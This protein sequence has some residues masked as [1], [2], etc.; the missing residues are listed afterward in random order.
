MDRERF[1][2]LARLLA[3]TGSRR[4]M[5]GALLGVSLF[6]RDPDV[7]AQHGNGKGKGKRNSD[8]GQ[9][10]Q[11]AGRPGAKHH[12]HHQH[13]HTQRQRRQQRDRQDR[14]G[15]QHPGPPVESRCGTKSC[16]PPEPGSDRTAC[17]FNGFTGQAFTG[18]DLHGAIFR[19]IDGRGTS[20]AG[21]D[22]RGAVFTAACLR[23]ASFR[24][25]QGA[26]ATWEGACLVDADFTG[27]DRG[28]DVAA[29]DGALLCR[30]IRPDGAVANRDCGVDTARCRSSGGGSGPPPCTTAAD[31]PE[32]PG[33]TRV[34]TDG[35]CLS[36]P[37]GAGPDPSGPCAHCCGGACCL[38][39]A[40][41][42]NGE[43][44]CCAPN[45]SESNCG[46]DGCG[47]GG[48]CGTCPAD[49]VCAGVFIGN[50]SATRCLCT[51]ESC[52]QGCCTGSGRSGKEESCVA[53]CPA[54]ETCKGG[55]CVCVT[56]KACR[57]GQVCI[58]NTCVC[59]TAK[60]CRPY[61]ECVDHQC[62]CT[63]QSC[64]NGCCSAFES[65]CPLD[66]CA[67]HCGLPGTP[68]QSCHGDQ[69]CVDHR[70]L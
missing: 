4:A 41:A 49:L 40:T 1:D 65:C 47:G 11:G 18:Q 66:L 22:L 62:L 59:A 2:A 55:S 27:A 17:D 33:R 29:L 46:P 61:Q 44:P 14:P 53:L 51:A 58:D 45:C 24:E 30:T 5:L 16:A 19:R 13:T 36:A 50:Q 10:V 31:C 7:L 15:G 20:F 70:C 43:G 8:G 57:P 48:T 68:C 12:A 25:A 3:T 21:T 32:A 56:A 28:G 6:G 63:A 38:G 37:V 42:C 34:C 67:F 64:P 54:G 35:A 69:R 23:A 26:G 52:A 9:G 60:A 39:R